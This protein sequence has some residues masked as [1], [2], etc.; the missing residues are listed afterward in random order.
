[1][2]KWKGWEKESD[3]T[4]KP[5]NNLQGSEELIKEFEDSQD[6]EDDDDGARLCEHCQRIFVSYGALSRHIKE[7]HKV[8]DSNW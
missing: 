2:V 4:G 3:Q 5:V 6:N 1:M 7:A 8:R